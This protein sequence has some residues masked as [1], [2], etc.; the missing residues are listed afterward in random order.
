[1]V[2]V[3]ETQKFSVK[4]GF[5]VVLKV[6]IQAMRCPFPNR[7]YI[8]NSLSFLNFIFRGGRGCTIGLLSDNFF[9]E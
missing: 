6:L 7:G 4:K 5:N 3:I 2:F 1:L 8:D 9:V